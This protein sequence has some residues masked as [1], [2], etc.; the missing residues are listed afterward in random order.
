MRFG[1]SLVGLVFLVTFTG[2]LGERYEVNVPQADLD[3][4]NGGS[5]SHP[6]DPDYGRPRFF[7][8][9]G[10][11]PGRGSLPDAAWRGSLP[12]QRGS[13]P[14]RGSLPIGNGTLPDR[15]SLPALSRDTLPR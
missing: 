14:W 10:T 15:G 2:C 5:V 11:L 3:L 9:S 6:D 13:L 8:K 4:W 1:L 12:S 7:R